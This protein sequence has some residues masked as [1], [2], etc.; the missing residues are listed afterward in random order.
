MPQSHFAIILTNFK[1]PRNLPRILAYCEQSR[2]DPQIYLIDNSGDRSAEAIALDRPRVRYLPQAGNRGPSYRFR[3]SARLPHECLV[4]LDDD[5]YLRPEQIDALFDRVTACPDSLH[6][7][8]G[9]ILQPYEAGFRLKSGVKYCDSALPIVNRVYGYTRSYVRDAV[10]YA[11]ALGYSD[12]P[13]A[14]PVDDILLSMA[15]RN[16]PRCHDLGPLED[17]PSSDDPLIAVWK[18][19]GFV[20]SRTRLVRTLLPLLRWPRGGEEAGIDA[21][22]GF[23]AASGANIAT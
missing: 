1:R 11:R 10:E 8:W 13:A 16:A 2:H 12:W 22:W 5:V 3:L 15:G 17:C 9:Q 20:E 23:R 4:C 14:G 18:M 7:V 6:G 19:A 21:V